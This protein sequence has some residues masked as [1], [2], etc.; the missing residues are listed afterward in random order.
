MGNKWAVPGY[1]NASRRDVIA[2]YNAEIRKAKERLESLGVPALKLN[3]PNTLPTSGKQALNRVLEIKKINQENIEVKQPENGIFKTENILINIKEPSKYLFY[4]DK[5]KKKIKGKKFEIE[6][7]LFTS[8]EVKNI[9]EEQ[10]EVNKKRKKIGLSNISGLRFKKEKTYKEVI[11][12]IQF[13]GSS[14]GIGQEM[15]RFVDNFI[16][17]LKRSIDDAI[18]YNIYNQDTMEEVKELLK[19]IEKR[20]LIENFNRLWKIY[21]KSNDK[22]LFNMFAS[23]QT[24]FGE[25][26]LIDMLAQEYNIKIDIQQQ[27][28]WENF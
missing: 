19:E 18:F 4:Q 25:T 28:D 20:S 14:V 17:S 22:E 12:D 3:L 23:N 10:K 1:P 26:D 2:S 27:S 8:K 7:K 11:K 9:L 21:K 6:F 16:V 13:K 15:K 24:L 5:L